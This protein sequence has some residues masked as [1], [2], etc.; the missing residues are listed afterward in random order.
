MA[1]ER[2]L[3][4]RHTEKGQT[5]IVALILLGVL[6]VMGFIF[7]GVVSRSI[8]T[9]GVQQRRSEAVDLAD[10]GIRHA[11]AQMLNSSLGADWRPTPTPMA[12]DGNGLT[13]DPDALWL[14][15]A[16]GLE[17]RPGVVDQGGPDGLGP[18]TRVPFRNGRAIYRVRFAPSDA[19]IF[20]NDPSGA[21]RQPGKAR[22]YTI[23][24]SVGRPGVV[25]LNDPTS[26]P[27]GAG[28]V[29]NFTTSQELHQGLARLHARDNEFVQ[30]R[31]LVAFAS[32]GIIE[33]AKY[34][35]NKD[36]VTRPAE[37]GWPEGVGARFGVTPVTVP[38]ELGGTVS[39]P[40]GQTVTGSGG[41]YSN[42]DL[43]LHGPIRTRL[44][45]GMGDQIVINGV[46]TGANNALL[47]ILATDGFD[48]GGTTQIT[49][50]GPQLDS[51]SNAFTTAGG[52]IRDGF[53][54]TD[55]AGHARYAMYKSPPSFLRPDPQTNRNKYLDMTRNSGRLTGNGNT[56]RFGHGRGV[57]V[58][59]LADRQIRSDES[60]RE[61]AGTHESLFYDWLNPNNP[62]AN[63]GWQGPFYIPV[64]AYLTLQNDGFTITR[65]AR[66]PQ[67]ERTWR[68]PDGTDSGLSTILF[69]LGRPNPGAP[70]YIINSLTPG[71]NI[72]AANPN[73]AAG[74]PFD[75]VLYFEGNVRVRGVIPTDV[76][77]TVVSMATIYIEGSITKGIVDD[78]GMRINRPSRSM[79]MLAAKDYVALNTTQFFGPGSVGV[80]EV[81]E[82]PGPGR[83]NPVRVQ[84]AGGSLNFRTEMLLQ[85]GSGANPSLWS[86][87][88]QNYREYTNPGGNTGP[89]ID[90]LMLVAHAM[91][92]GPAPYSFIQMDVNYGLPSPTYF[93]EL[94]A[95]N[96]ARTFYPPG[97]THAPIKGLGDRDWQRYTRF[98]QL[99]FPLIF[100]GSSTITGGGS[101]LTQN[102][103]GQEGNYSFLIQETN[104]LTIRTTNVGFGATNDYLLARAAVVPH[105]V[106]IEASIFAENGSF[107]IIPGHWFNPNPN[108]RRDNYA[109]LGPDDTERQLQRVRLFGAFPEMPF[110]GEPLDVRVTVLGA[111]SENMPP[112]ISQ[113]AEWLRKWGWIPREQG[114]SGRLIP[115]TH[116]PAGYDITA[117][118]DLYVPNMRIVYDPSL[119]TG[120]VGGFEDTPQNPYIRMDNFGRPLPPMPRLPVS[121][122]LAYFGEVNP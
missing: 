116:V 29:A 64:G 16:S 5:L 28:Q 84:A 19:N 60:G 3:S 48:A 17:Y 23:I 53:T 33:H 102:R 112:P 80:D 44:N 39:A 47:E 50:T 111:V 1:L 40:G 95:A 57:Y 8:I 25:N 20:V 122:T 94:N 24:E 2:T 10:A 88:A 119:A 35:T 9:A 27:E 113:Q 120:R 72:N 26:L 92:D 118:N 82:T 73:F 34:I 105:D 117:G 106:R 43:T 49:L 65:D 78:N 69:R 98:E 32:I 85:P 70:L 93:F 12:I 81:E 62:Q 21:L 58:D 18:Y 96:S 56:G 51:R 4:K 87:Y 99:G 30:S 37:L 75:G 42:A 77:M 121:P 90:S 114:A 76:Q 14:R 36:R 38:V 110:Y 83:W 52:L 108:D 63:S 41:I 100:P 115:W 6:L 13:R 91:D 59:N 55:P 66:A 103:P 101:L 71:A 7:L 109:N 46:L 45:R 97:Q 31:R 22:M 61:E 86:T 74:V 54:G 79:L 68:G 104:D 67:R 107:F 15:P 11:H 89:E